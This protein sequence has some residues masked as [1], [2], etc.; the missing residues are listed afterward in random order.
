MPPPEV[1]VGS[2]PPTSSAPSSVNGP[3]SPRAQ[4]P[5]PSSDSGTSGLN[6]S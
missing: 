6:A 4:K 5:Y 1:L 3:P 2:R